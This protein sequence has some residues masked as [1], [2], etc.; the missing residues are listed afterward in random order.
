MQ[1]HASIEVQPVDRE[2]TEIE[3]SVG[4]RPIDLPLRVE[5]DVECG[6][7]D[8]QLVGA[9]FAAHQIAEAEF[10]VEPLGAH[11][12]EVVGAADNHVAQAE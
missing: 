6:A 4:D 1:R 5:P 8:G 2:R 11:L 10:D 7:A 3:L 9:P 12:A